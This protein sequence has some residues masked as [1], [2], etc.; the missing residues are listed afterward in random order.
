MDDR[1]R[2]WSKVDIRSDDECWPWLAGKN[3][4]GYGIFLLNRKCRTAPNVAL[5]FSGRKVPKGKVTR[6]KCHNKI[7]CNPGH[8]IE[9]TIAENTQD[10][11]EAGHFLNGSKKISEFKV[12]MCMVMLKYLSQRQVALRM[13][14][15]V[16]TVWM[17]KHGKSHRN[18]SLP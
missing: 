7:C 17:I 5:E 1:K 8:L 15:N 3:K 9:G 11:V 10:S 13:G 4:K 6:H 2:F 12:M 16:K 18:I 14:L